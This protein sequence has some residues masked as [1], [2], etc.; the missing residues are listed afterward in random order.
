MK[1]IDYQFRYS[2]VSLIALFLFLLSCSS[3]SSTMP[4][5]S[6]TGGGGGGSNPPANEVW[7]QGFA[8]N[9]STLTVAVNTTVK[10][11]NKHS[12]THTVTSDTGLFDS[13]GI[14]P[15][16]IY[17]FK[18]TQAGTFNYH[19]SIHPQMTATIIVQ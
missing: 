10:W 5:P 8:F 12:T 3:S 14:S 9:P 6:N 16:G 13:G 1:K 4:M 15:N 17:N 18:F 7:I 11:T 19:C 2:A